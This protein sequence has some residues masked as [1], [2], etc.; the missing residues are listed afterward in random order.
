MQPA[1]FFM[2]RIIRSP[3]QLLPTTVR[4]YD[5]LPQ[6]L[7][8]SAPMILALPTLQPSH[9]PSNSTPPLS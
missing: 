8:P 4:L 6:I 1:N 7:T 5:T 3:N 9:I 2:G